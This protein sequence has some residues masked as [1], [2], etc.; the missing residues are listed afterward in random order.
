MRIDQSYKIVILVKQIQIMK[1][2]A[3][4]ISVLYQVICKN[5]NSSLNKLRLQ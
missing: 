4:V 2:T 5:L 3:L 1:L